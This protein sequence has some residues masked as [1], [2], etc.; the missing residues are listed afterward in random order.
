MTEGDVNYRNNIQDFIDKLKGVLVKR[1]FLML[2][3][4]PAFDCSSVP[5]EFAYTHSIVLETDKG[6]LKIRT[7]MTSSGVET[8]WIEANEESLDCQ[9]SKMVNSKV[10]NVGYDNRLNGYPYKIWIKFENSDLFIY[11]AEIYDT[12]DG[13]LEYKVNDEMILIFDNL[14][15]SQKFE[16]KLNYG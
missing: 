9:V 12:E 15:E 1:I 7:A 3:T 8:F 13:Q 14:T 4:T 11:S 5:F 2:D 10:L 6:E 16:N